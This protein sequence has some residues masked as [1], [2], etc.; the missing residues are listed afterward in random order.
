[1][2]FLID[3]DP[4]IDDAI[5]LLFLL[6]QKD[7]EIVGIS[8]AFGNTSAEGCARNALDILHMAGADGDVPVCVGSTEPLKG[9]PHNWPAHIHGGN[10]V[11]DVELEHSA[12]SPVEEDV[13][14][15]LYRIAG[16]HKGEVILIT[17][18]RMTN[19]ARTIEKYPDFPSRIRRVITMGGTLYMPGNVTPVCEAN[20]AGDPEAADI[21]V[22][23]DWDMT[24]VG[25][26]VTMRTVLTK[27]FVEKMH[28][29]SRPGC[30]AQTAFI[31]EAMR[32]YMKA[33]QIHGLPDICPVHDPLAVMAAYDPSL[34]EVRRMITRIECGGTYSRG[35]VITDTRP[36]P[37]DGRHVGHAVSVDSQRALGTLL[38]AFQ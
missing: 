16:E 22:Q 6:N 13:R 2:K 19:I 23:Q 36:L 28:E 35:R 34:V 5:A 12:F 3:C 18:G 17:L 33:G 38:R 9:K 24:M 32:I 20:I 37:I 26:D 21:C 4:G 27:E 7:A 14:D 8:V 15:F 10:G 11:G 29:H 25:M 1:M 31:K 30:K